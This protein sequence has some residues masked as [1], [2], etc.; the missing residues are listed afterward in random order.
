MPLGRMPEHFADAGAFE[1][2]AGRFVG[3]R[4]LDGPA[5][6]GRRRRREERVAQDGVV[7]RGALSSAEICR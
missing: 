6:L 4:R 5:L 1:V 2:E 7:E 3:M